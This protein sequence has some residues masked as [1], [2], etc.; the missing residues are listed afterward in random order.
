[1]S[2]TD[3]T[4]TR[5]K[6]LPPY[7]FAEIDRL[8]KEV[9]AKGVDI[10]NLGI[11]DP[12]LPTPKHIID[13]LK[14]TSEDP[15]NHQYPSYSGMGDY[16]AAVAKW[17]KGRFGVS[18]DPTKEIVSLIGSKEGIAHIPL[19]FVEPGDLVIVPDPAYP[20]YN[21]GTI[22][23]GGEP[24]VLPLRAENGFLADLDEIPVDEAQ[25]AKMLFLNYP[26]N[27][28]G[29]TA[30]KDYLKKCVDWAKE[31]NV[32]LCHDAAYIDMAYDG[33]RPPS[34]LEVEG[35]MDVAVEFH[36]L[37]KTYNMTGWRIGFAAGN[38]EIIAGLGRVKTNIDSG[39]FQAVQ[40]AGMAALEGDQQCVADSCRIY[41]ERRDLLVNGLEEAGLKAMLPKAT[42]YVWCEVPKGYSSADFTSHLLSNMG[43]VT[44]PGNGFG[45]HGEG[46]V[47][48]ALTVDVE[49]M[50]EAVDRI[51]KTGF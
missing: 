47:R 26:N 8:K 43:I 23:A 29:A 28:T 1:M 37:S 49:R 38:P 42:F 9:A 5:L 33:Y 4:A 18:L 17:F 10:I 46:F 40:Y 35:A 2:W 48:F 12:D 6:R 15:A 7:L 34:I 44:T 3:Q 11:G 16:R 20:V 27:P 21:A 36:S 14:L 13:R 19:A 32:I 39:V 51:K 25:R 41:Q 45:G 30:G 50:K 22:F 31:H 24:R